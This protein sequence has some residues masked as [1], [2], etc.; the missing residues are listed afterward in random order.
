M[1]IIVVFPSFS[2]HSYQELLLEL[3]H[4]NIIHEI[5]QKI[6]LLDLLLGRE[7]PRRWR[8]AFY[9]DGGLRLSL[10]GSVAGWPRHYGA[11]GNRPEYL[12]SQ[13]IAKPRKK[14][15]ESERVNEREGERKKKSGN[16]ME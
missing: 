8:R 16:R 5:I 4:A 6:H 12:V 10:P 9:R 2:K 3:S 15:R 14:E 1:A 13:W 7:R 11:S